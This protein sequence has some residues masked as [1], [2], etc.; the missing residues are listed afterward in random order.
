MLPCLI[1]TP[2]RSAVKKTMRKKTNNKISKN[3]NIKAK[4]EYQNLKAPSNV[5]MQ[6]DKTLTTQIYF[7]LTI[8]QMEFFLNETRLQVDKENE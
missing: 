8:Q 6:S 5:K 4:T 3:K 1:T 7:F 2:T